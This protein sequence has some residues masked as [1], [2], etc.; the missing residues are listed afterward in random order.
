MYPALPRVLMPCCQLTIFTGTCHPG[1]SLVTFA[2]LPPSFMQTLY[3][4]PRGNRVKT[5]KKI[6][7][8]R[9]KR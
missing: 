7:W 3:Y 5:Q 6:L 8:S 1:C 2:K 9:L 4:K